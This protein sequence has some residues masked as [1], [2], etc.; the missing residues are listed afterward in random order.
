MW[1]TAQSL[2]ALRNEVKDNLVAITII[3]S[4]PASYSTL[5]TILIS[6]DTQDTESVIT[7]ILV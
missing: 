5:Q 2:R 4:L 7:K 1:S 3:L 6:Q